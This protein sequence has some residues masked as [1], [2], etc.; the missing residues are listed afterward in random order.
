MHTV[1]I[2][3]RHARDYHRL[4]DAAHLPDLGITSTADPADA[5]SH[6]ADVD[7]AFGEHRSCDRSCR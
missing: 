6:A 3:S 5:A 4:V 7:L 2:L 1:L